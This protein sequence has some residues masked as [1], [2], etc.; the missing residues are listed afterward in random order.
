MADMY[1]LGVIAGVV[2][3]IAFVLYIWDRYS[4]EIPVDW[5]DAGK[6]ALSAGGVAGGV[7]YAVGTDGAVDAVETVTTAAQEMFVGKP[8]F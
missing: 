6:L 4:K 5:L 8:S 2:A 1:I 3:V 7:A